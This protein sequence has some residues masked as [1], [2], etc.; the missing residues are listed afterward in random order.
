MAFQFS[1]LRISL[2]CGRAS[3]SFYSGSFLARATGLALGVAADRLFADPARFHPVAGFGQA[4]G[5]L[6][7]RLYADSRSSGVAFTA[8]SVAIPTLAA[9][10]ISR[11][12]PTA[13]LALCTWASLG[14]TTLRR[15]GL[16]MAQALEQSD[17]DTARAWVA[18]LCSRDPQALDDVGIARA[19]VESLAENTSDAVTATLVWGALAGP[20]GVVAHRAAN[21]LDAMVGYRSA[22]YARF[23]WASARLD[24]V[25]GLV[26]ARVT[27]LAS[28]LVGPYH[29]DAWKAW[30]RDAQGHPSPNAGVVEASAAGALGL[31]L[32]GPTVYAS[33]VENRPVLG[34]GRIPEAEDIRRVVRFSAQ[35]QYTVFG[36]CL[37]ALAAANSAA[38]GRC[39]GKLQ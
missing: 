27:A 7:Q 19:T 10:M 37:V 34:D 25:L 3:Q 17:L 22:R 24:D 12:A 8:V 23:G 35:V 15:T 33:G 26:P 4:A 29:R 39:R 36:L 28:V 16:Q 20:A 9:A 11:C 2:S 6:Q 14:G 38:F 18:W 1:R 30:R 31:Q 32:G 13:T 21:T 5:W